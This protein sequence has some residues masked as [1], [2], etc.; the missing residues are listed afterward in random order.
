[1]VEILKRF[2]MLDCKSMTAS[3]TT[4]LQL[5]NDDKSKTVDANLYRQI[6]GSLMYLTITRPD[7]CFVVNTLIQY[8]VNPRHFHL[9]GEKTCDEVSKRD[10]KLWS[11]IC[12]K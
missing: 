4:N 6:I 9:V 7:I 11:Q 12:I 1:M 5:L 2:G 3:M 10:V 8:M